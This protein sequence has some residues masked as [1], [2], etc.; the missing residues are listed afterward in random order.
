M[1]SR[2]SMHRQLIPHA[3]V[4]CGW[5]LDEVMEGVMRQRT[6]DGMEVIQAVQ[7]YSNAMITNMGLARMRR[8]IGDE[9]ASK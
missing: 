7:Q 2:V 9:R 1:S 8:M 6:T 3:C 5:Q 4:I